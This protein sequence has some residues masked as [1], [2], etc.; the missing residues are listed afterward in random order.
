M[1]RDMDLIRQLLLKI[2]ISDT[3][4]V[5]DVNISGYPENQIDYNLDLLVSA[6]LVNGTSE[7]TFDDT[8]FVNLRGLTW[9]GHEL[10]D[11]IRSESVWNRTKEFIKDR[12]LDVGSLPIEVFK[13]VAVDRIKDM[14]M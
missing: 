8:L 12:G 6:G 4:Q 11:A 13:S 9:E 14:L 2:E 1:R 5:P 7:W 10:L 3:R